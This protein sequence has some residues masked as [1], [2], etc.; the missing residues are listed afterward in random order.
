MWLKCGVVFMCDECIVF[1]EPPNEWCLIHGINLFQC[2][3]HYAV[4]MHSLNQTYGIIAAHIEH[5][6]S[7]K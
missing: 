1:E 2:N 4:E 3:L 7:R 6:N 5:S